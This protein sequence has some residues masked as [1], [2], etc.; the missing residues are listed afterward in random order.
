MAVPLL[1][2]PRPGLAERSSSLAARLARARTRALVGREPERAVLDRVLSG[3]A[4]APVVVHLHGPGG[5]GKSS[6]LLHAAE[7]AAFAGRRVVHVDGRF[8][9]T[10]PRRLEDIAAA[11]CTDPGTVLLVD[12]V[13]QCPPLEAWLRETFLPRLA[14]DARVVLASRVAPDAEWSLD[15]G[16]AP[17]FTALALRPLDTAGSHALL[18][19]RGVP[20]GRRAALVAFAGGNPLALSLAASSSASSEP[21]EP[22]GHVLTTLVDRLVGDVPTAVH[23]RALEVAALACV[24][25]ESLLRTA[26]GEADAASAFSWLRQQPY[27]ESTPEGL[28][29]H[30][31][32]R[33]TL[34]A[35]L[36]WRDPE[37]HDAV[38]TRIAA[39]TLQAVRAAAEDDAVSRVAEWVF[40]RDGRQNGLA[41]HQFD[42]SPLR[43]ADVP[44]VLRLAEDAASAVAHWVRRQPQAF[45]VYRHAGTTIPVGFMAI[46]RLTAELPEDRAADP[47]VAAV[48]DAIAAV[49]P[50]GRGE[51]LGVRRF[52][53]HQR[54]S[55]LLELMNRRAIA[56]E[57]R[58]SG[59]ALSFAV[60]DISRAGAGFREVAAGEVGGRHV[61]GRDWRRQTVDQWVEHEVRAAAAPVA[62]WPE[63]PSVDAQHQWQRDELERGVLDA[64][65][66]WHTPRAFATSV[67]LRSSLVPTV[68]A[69]PVAD[70][71]HA[72]TTAL[73]ALQVDPAGIK[74]HEVLTTTYIAAPRTLK[75]AALRLGVP[76][77]TYRRILARAK[78]RLIDQ[79]L[80]PVDEEQ[81]HAG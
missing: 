7:R 68:S 42:E 31:A 20:A 13:E 79:L 33:A 34:D 56:D 51:H 12:D 78:N 72:I 44:E 21:W 64:L 40:L 74:A 60:H 32:V 66:W 58:A 9:G 19:A 29:P 25:R 80:G 3:A 81:S 54:S 2:G 23:R 5:I 73:D 63:T 76:Y 18:A 39:A 37:R 59:R 46:L 28:A 38:R 69:D 16:W 8:P 62:T 49:A 65:R 41:H 24:T 57:M 4:D 10:D 61:V 36:R 30:D 27:I 71:R 77:G 43:P 55:A 52:T 35:D 70:L 1:S 17:L 53:V 67:L 75:A 45:R 14:E 26:L 50:L 11:A 48:W 6:L 22:A 47:V 15:P